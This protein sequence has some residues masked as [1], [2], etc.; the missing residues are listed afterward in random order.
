M[1]AEK[2]SLHAAVLAANT[3]AAELMERWK[4]AKADADIA[5]VRSRWLLLKSARPHAC[6]IAR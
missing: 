4:R 1:Q 5:L 3:A 6:F 2:D